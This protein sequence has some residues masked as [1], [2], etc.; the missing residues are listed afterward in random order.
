MIGKFR[1][2][3]AGVCAA[4]MR[5]ADE[6]RPGQMMCVIDVVMTVVRKTNADDAC[7]E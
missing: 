4:E 7:R 3:N 2:N 1:E 5:P 6:K